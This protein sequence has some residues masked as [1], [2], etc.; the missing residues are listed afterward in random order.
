MFS[1]DPNG[2]ISYIRQ[3]ADSKLLR[4]LLLPTHASNKKAKGEICASS[5]FRYLIQLT[6]K[7]YAP[8]NAELFKVAS[9]HQT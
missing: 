8:T 2:R 9:T 1:N 4:L 3:A 5:N 7:G 6:L